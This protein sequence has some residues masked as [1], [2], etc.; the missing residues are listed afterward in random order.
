MLDIGH[1]SISIQDRHIDEMRRMMKKYKRIEEMVLT[2]Q[3]KKGK[4]AFQAGYCG[5]S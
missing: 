1:L 2:S 4:L 5:I 3:G